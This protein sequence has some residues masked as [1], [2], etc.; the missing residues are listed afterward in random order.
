MMKRIIIEVCVCSLVVIVSY[1]MVKYYKHKLD[2]TEQAVIE[3]RQDVLTAESAV[4]RL[5]DQMTKLESANKVIQ[6]KTDSAIEEH[7]NRIENI[8]KSGDWLD[9]RLPDELRDA[10]NSSCSSGNTPANTSNEVQP[11]A[12]DN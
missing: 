1:S 6:T 11:S 7:E 2:E 5:F 8:I 12:N 10:F 3:L 9:C 4:E